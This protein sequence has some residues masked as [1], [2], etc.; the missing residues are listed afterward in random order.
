[1][2]TQNWADFS[3]CSIALFIDGS[4]DLDVDANGTPLIDD[5]LMV[6]IK[7]WWE[8]LKFCVKVNLVLQV[9]DIVCD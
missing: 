2:T 7:E 8:K 9:W 4:T 5:D 1:M 3:A 6:F